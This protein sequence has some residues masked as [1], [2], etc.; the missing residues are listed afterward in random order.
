MRLVLENE[1][2][3]AP[4]YT[5]EDCGQ[6]FT[7]LNDQK[8]V[9]AVK[10]ESPAY[11]FRTNELFGGG[12]KFYFRVTQTETGLSAIAE[13]QDTNSCKAHPQLSGSCFEIRGRMTVY[14]GS[15]SIRIWPVGTKRLLGV[16]EGRF[17]ITKGYGNLP[18]ELF[19]QL[20]LENAM[21]ADFTIC[22]FTDDEPGV[23]RLVCVE[24]AENISIR[25]WP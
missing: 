22:P 19:E 25:D 13:A 21:Y 17:Y 5:Q 11:L 6:N 2:F 18:E 24:S 3:A 7:T 4:I 14:N 12:S 1:E 16:S 20:S 23:M 8:V 15:P 10:Q 9:F